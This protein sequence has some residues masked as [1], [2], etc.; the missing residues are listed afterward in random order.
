MEPA[1]FIVGAVVLVAVAFL[2]G[3]ARANRRIGSGTGQSS[4][5]SGETVHH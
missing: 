5:G 4:D 2:V 3:R 1:S